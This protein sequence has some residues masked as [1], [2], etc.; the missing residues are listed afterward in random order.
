MP[1]SGDILRKFY[2]AAAKKEI[3]PVRRSSQD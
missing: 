3:A 1:S 2:A